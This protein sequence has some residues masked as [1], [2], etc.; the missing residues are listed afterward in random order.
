VCL[1]DAVVCE[2]TGSYHKT[3]QGLTHDRVFILTR[4]CS[5]IRKF[6]FLLMHTHARVLVGRGRVRS[7]WNLLQNRART[8]V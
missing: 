3:W 5:V 8:H 7:D 4:S 1:F 2:G 6:K